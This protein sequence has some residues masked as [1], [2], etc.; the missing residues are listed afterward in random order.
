MNEIMEM[1]KNGLDITIYS[2]GPCEENVHTLYKD[3]LSQ[4]GNKIIYT[5]EKGLLFFK[6]MHEQSLPIAYNKYRKTL[7]SYKKTGLQIGG[8]VAKSTLKYYDEKESEALDNSVFF[9][10]KLIE[11]IENKKIT[12]IYAPFGNGDAE[13]AMMIS[14]HTNI[15]YYF[16][17]HAFDLFSS[18]YF[19]NLKAKTCN[20]V[21]TISEYNKKYM[22]KNLKMPENKITVKR[23]NFLKPDYNSIKAKNINSPFIF[24]AGRLNEMKGFEYSIKAFAKFHKKFRRFHYFIAGSGEL[25][26]SLKSLVASLKLKNNI[27]FIGHIK[28]AEVLQYLKGAKF[29]ILSSIKT[30]DNDQEGLPT[31]FAESMSVGTPCIGTNYSAIPEI[32]DHKINGMLAKEK[33]IDDITKKMIDLKTL[34]DKDKQNFISKSCHSK[35]EKL[36]DNNYNIHLLINKLK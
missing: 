30:K 31:M 18:Y 12:K 9:I 11:D 17:C 3:Q 36:F 10:S 23:I 26:D 22:V 27:H 28:N 1:H 24:S 5:G 20:H 16:S 19:H 14:Y 6:G 13:I 25:E 35:I 32:I 29:S 8:K 7:E 34:L 4:I 21:F 2:R 15:P 33:D